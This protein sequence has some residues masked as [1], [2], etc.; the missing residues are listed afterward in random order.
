MV[1]RYLK[2]K[3]GSHIAHCNCIAR[4]MALLKIRNLTCPICSDIEKYSEDDI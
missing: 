1:F 2:C 4:D 3:E